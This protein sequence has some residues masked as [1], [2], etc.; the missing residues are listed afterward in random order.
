MNR[1]NVDWDGNEL[2]IVRYSWNSNED[3]DLPGIWRTRRRS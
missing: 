2:V 1:L 3:D